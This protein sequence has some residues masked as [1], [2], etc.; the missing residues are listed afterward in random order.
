[1]PVLRRD[2][3]AASTSATEMMKRFCVGDR[4]RPT[5]ESQSQWAWNTRRSAWFSA[6]R[7]LSRPLHCLS[8]AEDA[9]VRSVPSRS[10]ERYAEKLSLHLLSFACT[11]AFACCMFACLFVREEARG[12]VNST[13][14]STSRNDAT[15]AESKQMYNRLHTLQCSVF[16]Q[17]FYLSSTNLFY[18]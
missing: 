8:R 18:K 15:V 10:A 12:Q 1:M 6:P 5:R 13:V 7:S 17:F 4:L 11:F 9:P 3:S 2:V 14:Q 16:Y